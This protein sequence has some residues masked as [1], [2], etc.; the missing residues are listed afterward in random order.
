MGIP[1]VEVMVAIS[2]FEA[3]QKRGE[4]ESWQGFPR[5]GESKGRG[6]DVG[7]AWKLVQT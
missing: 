2:F 7:L 3:G 1:I 5:I 6:R 4:G